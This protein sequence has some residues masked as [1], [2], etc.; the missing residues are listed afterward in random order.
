MKS[1]MPLALAIFV[2]PVAAAHADPT[3]LVGHYDNN[4]NPPGDGNGYET[5]GGSY[6]VQ[7][8]ATFDHN[9]TDS[10]Y[11]AATQKNVGDGWLSRHSAI[12]I[13]GGQ[14]SGNSFNGLDAEAT[15][16]SISGGSFTDNGGGL[17]AT[18]HSTVSIMGGSFTGN[19]SAG[20]DAQSH[21]TVT[22]SGGSFSGNHDTGVDADVDST[23]SVSGGFFTGNKCCGLEVMAATVSVTGGRFT[24]N[25]HYG[26]NAS[27]DARVSV[28][29]GQFTGNGTV[30]LFCGDNSTITL[31]G[32][33]N[34][35]GALV[36][37]GSF[38]GILHD[39]GP[40]QTLTYQTTRSHSRIVLRPDSGLN[41]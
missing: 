40:S 5:D 8:P 41:G 28:T 34:K 15:T 6:S 3:V 4:P 20:L 36:G 10:S 25:G 33:F 7:D 24:G 16:L 39:G 29:G 21:S 1:W 12:S 31:Y 35:Y 9:A 2:P 27:Y 13:T 17:F 32:R 38:T 22:I 18:L 23:V 14:F 19:H 37:K 30:A 26:L 11:D